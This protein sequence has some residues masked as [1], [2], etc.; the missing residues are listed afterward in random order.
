MSKKD[1]FFSNLFDQVSK[2]VSNLGKEVSG[3]FSQEELGTT[4]PAINL[5]ETDDAYE[6]E[7]AA[8]G[9]SKEDFKVNL[10]DESITISADKES[11]TEDSGRNYKKREFNYAK[12][13]RSFSIPEEVDT[14]MVKASY[15]EGILTIT[16]PKK[17]EFKTKSGREI[18][19]F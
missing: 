10:G 12:F 2:E 15:E 19:I 3:Y 4:V 14:S 18:D 1:D 6:V 17:E 7:V 9:M 11:S 13:S 16:L 5:I 8:P